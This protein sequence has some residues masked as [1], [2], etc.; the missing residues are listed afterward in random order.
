MSS[1]NAPEE[2]RDERRA[3]TRAQSADDHLLAGMYRYDCAAGKALLL[4]GAA[5]AE[6][7]PPGANGQCRA[8]TKPD[9]EC[10]KRTDLR[11][12]G[13]YPGN[14]RCARRCVYRADPVWGRSSRYR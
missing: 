12:A 10:T 5:I 1:R 14:Q 4:A 11:C 2:A 13:P 7:L 9:C 8:Y 3:K 6:W